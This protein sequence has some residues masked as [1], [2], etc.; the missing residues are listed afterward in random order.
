M[1]LTKVCCNTKKYLWQ[2]ISGIPKP[3]HFPANFKSYY[4]NFKWLNRLPINAPNILIGA[5]VNIE[6]GRIRLQQ[7][8]EKRKEFRIPDSGFKQKSSAIC[9]S[10]LTF[11]R[12]LNRKILQEEFRGQLFHSPP[13]APAPAPI[14]WVRQPSTAGLP[15][16]K[17]PN[18]KKMN[19]AEQIEIFNSKC[20]ATWSD[21]N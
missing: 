13:P 6:A 12:W 8:K 16:P 14:S 2:Q 5:K 20:I 1:R 10:W 21:E 11:H 3:A 19:F 9:C 7:K 15:N 18:L 4:I 17:T